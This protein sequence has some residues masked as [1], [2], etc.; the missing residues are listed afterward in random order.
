[1]K[2]VLLGSGGWIPTS[3]RETCCL[4]VRKGSDVL[5]VDAGTGLRRAVEHDHLFS[6]VR[7]VHMILSHFHLDHVVGLGY[8]P[9]LRLP[10]RLSIWG[11]GTSLY[12]EST[13]A[14][15]E[16]IL[17]APFFSADISGFA[18]DVGELVE[19]DND[20]GAFH[21]VARTQER[22]SAPS[23]AFRIDDRIAYCSDTAYDE[24]NVELARSSELLF[25]EAWAADEDN[26]TPDIHT[27][28]R[29]AGEIA[30]L[31]G[32]DRLV[33]IH[34]NPL[35]SDSFLA[36]SAQTEFPSSIVGSDLLEIDVS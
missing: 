11:P 25:H 7:S 13:R 20:C 5:L 28:A 10:D 34:V 2:A 35:G 27:S 4:Y 14:V 6:G 22:H 12:G 24:G 18:S 15:L 19:G 3:T 23:L 9:A 17:G 31:A 16:R 29:E 1:M 33:L 32:V 26:P 8:A 36:S 21:V 30:R